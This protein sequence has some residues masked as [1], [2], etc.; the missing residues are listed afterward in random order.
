M[1]HD[2]KHCLICKRSNATLHW[3]KDAQTGDIWV[4]CQGKCQRGYSLLQ[5][6]HAAEISLADFLK[7]DFFFKEATPNELQVMQWPHKFIPLSDPRAQR[8]V[9]YVKSRGLSLDGDFYYDLERD[10]IVFP[11]YYESHF[12][13]AQIRFI[14][15][16][17]N[18]DGD[19]QKIDTVPG[20]RLGMLFGLWNQDRFLTNVKAVGV[21]EGYFNAVAL[22]QAFNIKYGGVLNNPWKFICTSGC[23]PSGHHQDVLSDLIKQNVKV[24]GAYDADEPG[25][26][27][28]SKLVK[29]G[30]I[31][32]HSSTLDDS[33]DWN[34]MLKEIGHEELANL[35]IKNTRRLK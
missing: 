34:D 17:I 11:Y 19:V 25:M 16:R 33:R 2:T 23:N 6:C 22:Q 28:L 18:R 27:G 5:Y 26:K 9:E 21:C 10:G 31:T 20:T 32:H 24:F 1:L 8:G 35:F 15:H 3:H 14:K 30:C 13:G 12:C 7:G 29:A 4:W